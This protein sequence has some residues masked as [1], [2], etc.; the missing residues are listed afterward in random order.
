MRSTVYHVSYSTQNLQTPDSAFLG[1]ASIT[2]GIYSKSDYA[3]N[4]AEAWC[5][6]HQTKCLS[7]DEMYSD[8]RIEPF[9]LH[10]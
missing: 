8:I 9:V 10:G 2:I 4:A 1:E 7:A 5:R 3:V 6:A